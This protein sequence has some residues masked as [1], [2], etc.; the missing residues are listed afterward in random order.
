MPTLG[1]AVGT[2]Q[3]RFRRMHVELAGRCNPTVANGV[4]ETALDPGLFI[5]DLATASNGISK[6]R[7]LRIGLEEV[8]ASGAAAVL[9]DQDPFRFRTVEKRSRMTLL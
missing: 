7:S 1:A 3:A 2:S 9:N 5:D 4:E 8:S 6:N